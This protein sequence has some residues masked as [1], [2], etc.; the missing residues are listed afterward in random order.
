MNT[1]TKTG[2]DSYSFFMCMFFFWFIGYKTDESGKTRTHW[3]FFDTKFLC[4]IT[5]NKKRFS[6]YNV[7][8]SQNWCRIYEW[9]AT[10]NRGS[11]WFPSSI[12]KNRKIKR[13]KVEIVTTRKCEWIRKNYGILLTSVRI[14]IYQV[15][16]SFPPQNWK[17]LLTKTHYKNKRSKFVFFLLSPTHITHKHTQKG[18]PNT[19]NI[20]INCKC[21]SVNLKLN[22]FKWVNDYEWNKL[23]LAI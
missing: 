3:A 10:V 15:P 23:L 16:D 19:I 17:Q 12:E 8:S 7:S 6:K 4:H 14:H 11:A 22:R 5:N 2:S 1:T 20:K 13:Q 18:A 21:I 9:I